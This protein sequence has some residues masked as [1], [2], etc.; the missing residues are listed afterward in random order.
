MWT[1]F[2]LKC[3]SD[4][5]DSKSIDTVCT[6]EELALIA[7][8]STRLSNLKNSVFVP[9]HNQPVYKYLTDLSLTFSQEKTIRITKICPADEMHVADWLENIG[10]CLRFQTLGVWV[11]C[12]YLMLNKENDMVYVYCAKDIGMFSTKLE[13]KV[14]KLIRNS[15]LI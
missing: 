9:I 7:K 15:I 3:L 8:N 6:T 11:G 10:Q 1:P 14:F 13:T 4:L 5:N 2:E 12:S